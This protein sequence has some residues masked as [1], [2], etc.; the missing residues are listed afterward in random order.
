MEVD[1]YQSKTSLD[2]YLTIPAGNALDTIELPVGLATVF[3]SAG[4]FRAGVEVEADKPRAGMNP[5]KILADI[6]RQGF[7]DHGVKVTATLTTHSHPP[8]R[9]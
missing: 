2:R 4:V 5:R 7:A 6:E 3:A 9:S 8:S 1:I